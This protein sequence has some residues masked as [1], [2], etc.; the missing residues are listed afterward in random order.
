MGTKFFFFSIFLFYFDELTQLAHSSI[1]G[2]ISVLSVHVMVSSSGL[3]L[4]QDSVGLDRSNVLLEDLSAVD[5]L[6][7]DLSDLV[8][9][10]HLVPER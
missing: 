4:D 9:S 10:L 1:E 5:E 7:V 3:I 2:S 8:D 6:S